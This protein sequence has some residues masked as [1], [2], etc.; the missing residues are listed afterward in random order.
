MLSILPC[1]LPH[2]S[3]LPL[4]ER[5]PRPSGEDSKIDTRA[6]IKKKNNVAP[7]IR[8]LFMWIVASVFGQPAKAKHRRAAYALTL[9]R[10]CT[11]KSPITLETHH[12]D[13]R[14]PDEL[15]SLKKSFKGMVWQGLE[16]LNTELGQACDATGIVELKARF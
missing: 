8:V 12:P 4:Q 10:F 3:S 2:S 15:K 13:F 6:I 7:V 14:S 11:T 5:T 16:I 1:F 9:Y